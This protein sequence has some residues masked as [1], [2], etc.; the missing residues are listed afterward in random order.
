MRIG[1]AAELGALHA[2]QTFWR[3]DVARASTVASVLFAAIMLAFWL[4][5]RD[6]A[7]GAFAVVCAVDRG[8][9]T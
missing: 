2:R 9:R 4:G 1:D 3:V 8:R 5:T 6:P 7:Y